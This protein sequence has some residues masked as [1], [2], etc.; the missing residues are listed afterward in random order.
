MITTYALR[1]YYEQDETSLT[2]VM[3][4]FWNVDSLGVSKELEL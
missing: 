1:A 2:Q 3:K 4:Y